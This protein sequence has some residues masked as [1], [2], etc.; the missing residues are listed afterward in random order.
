LALLAPVVVNIFAFHVFLAP[1]GLPVAI[2]VSV[3]EVCLAWVYRD[4]FRSMLRA[5][6][7]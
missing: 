7:A 4:A 6:R 2:A 3:L 1:Q 5:A